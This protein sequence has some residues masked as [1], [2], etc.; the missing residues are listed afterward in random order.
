MND[1]K[2]I[3]DEHRDPHSYNF[4]FCCPLT[5]AASSDIQEERPIHRDLRSYEKALN[6]QR[7][8]SQKYY[9]Y[10]GVKPSWVGQKYYTLV[11]TPNGNTE[12][13]TKPTHN[14]NTRNSRDKEVFNQQI[15]RSDTIDQPLINQN[16]STDLRHELGYWPWSVFYHEN[17]VQLCIAEA[18]ANNSL[19]H[20]P[21]ALSNLESTLRYNQ[22]Y[23]SYIK[24]PLS[25]NHTIT[26]ALKTW[27]K[28]DNFT[29]K[30]IGIYPLDRRHHHG[31]K[32]REK[33]SMKYNV[34]HLRRD[35]K[36]VGAQRL[37]CAE[38]AT[39]GWWLDIDPWCCEGCSIEADVDDYMDGEFQDPEE[40]G[41]ARAV[42]FEEM[43]EQ[44]LEEGD[45]LWTCM[46]GD[47]DARRTETATAAA[48]TGGSEAVD[49]DKSMVEPSTPP[50]DDEHSESEW[51]NWSDIV[52]VIPEHS[53]DFDARS[54]L[55]GDFDVLSHAD[56]SSNDGDWEV[57]CDADPDAYV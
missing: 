5:A 2:S 35:A 34:A 15:Q 41:K 43:K 40:Y 56:L 54:R 38:I 32:Y 44:R 42:L 46:Y 6:R 28:E 9:G 36:S 49:D 52:V 47:R 10:R 27:T 57:L 23:T 29:I 55:D 3:P 4:S 12:T 22:Q 31:K 8:Q 19:T 16:T 13:H 48:A 39:S 53:G 45:A 26:L 33:A 14:H 11:L 21:T 25:P 51:D 20:A 24:H 18:R 30:D 1:S 7:K 17:S 50:V 37:E